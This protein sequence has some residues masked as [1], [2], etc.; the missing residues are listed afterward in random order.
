[1]D[2]SFHSLKVKDLIHHAICRKKGLPYDSISPLSFRR[3]KTVY[4]FAF[5]H[6]PLANASP[7]FVLL[8]IEDLMGMLY[9]DWTPEQW[10]DDFCD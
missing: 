9:F 2:E 10:C 4:E 3:H 7:I 1:M 8:E 6:N 5:A